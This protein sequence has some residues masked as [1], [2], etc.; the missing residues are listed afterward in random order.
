MHVFIFLQMKW[1][2][3]SIPP[4]F[5]EEEVSVPHHYA[6][7]P[8]IAFCISFFVFVS[9][10]ETRIFTICCKNTH[11]H[12]W[13]DVLRKCNNFWHIYWKNKV[14]FLSSTISELIRL[15]WD[16]HMYSDSKLV[17][18]LYCGFFFF[19]VALMHCF[20]FFYMVNMVPCSYS[21]IVML[22]LFFIIHCLA[23]AHLS[24]F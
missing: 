23:L 16:I 3:S 19:F 11:G 15:H 7:R 17:L 21:F 14:I 20:F 24:T 18:V 13:I 6:V 4:G 22:L 10:Q 8:S 1:F 12:E 9:F 5:P 2:V